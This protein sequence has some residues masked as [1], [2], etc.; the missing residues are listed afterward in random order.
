MKKIM[1][2]M[3]AVLGIA[4]LEAKEIRLIKKNGKPCK[5]DKENICYDKI[6]IRN[7]EYAH[8]QACENPGFEKCPKVSIVTVGGLA[9]FDFEGLVVN[10]E[11]EII[12]GETE[13][14]GIIFDSE[15][16]PI[17][18]NLWN[19]RINDDDIIEYEIELFDMNH[20]DW[21]MVKKD[22]HVGFIDIKGKEVVP[23]IYDEIELFDMFHD[24]WAMVKKDNHIG[25]IDYQG[26]E[27]VPLEYTHPND[28][29]KWYNKQKNK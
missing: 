21:A 27:V 2:T 29:I 25:F 9:N 7:T 11:S 22:N 26:K 17:A 8:Q 19:G 3:I 28:G 13:K 5:G 4:S 23:T 15:G 14:K 12:R 16:Q 1:I 24:G 6:Y 20:S 18:Y 10:V